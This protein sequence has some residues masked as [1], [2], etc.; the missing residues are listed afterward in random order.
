MGSVLQAYLQWEWWQVEHKLQQ[1]GSA[2][3]FVCPLSRFK[4]YEWRQTDI[5]Y[6]SSSKIRS[7]T[8]LPSS[9]LQMLPVRKSSS[10]L[11]RLYHVFLDN[12]LPRVAQLSSFINKLSDVTDSGQ[13]K[14][15]PIF[16]L[17]GSKDHRNLPVMSKSYCNQIWKKMDF[18]Q[19]VTF[20]MLRMHKTK[21]KEKSFPATVME[22]N[23]DIQGFS[24]IFGKMEM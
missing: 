14:P 16:S 4:S 10:F 12:S 2:L 7:S 20:I 6:V 19:A 21:R 17:P 15:S 23:Q 3:G 18:D 11:F 24:G 13:L 8:F 9:P 1:K 5:N 22:K